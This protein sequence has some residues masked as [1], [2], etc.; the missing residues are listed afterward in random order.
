MDMFR[1]VLL[2]ATKMR[3][4]I[5]RSCGNHANFQASRARNRCFTSQPIFLHLEAIYRNLSSNVVFIFCILLYSVPCN[6]CN[7]VK[8]TKMV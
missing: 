5:L 7:S 8:K 2:V 6:L 3:T 1:I 4:P